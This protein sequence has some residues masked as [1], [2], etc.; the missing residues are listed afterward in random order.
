MEKK[1]QIYLLVFLNDFLVFLWFLFLLFKC[2]HNIVLRDNLP[3]YKMSTVISTVAHFQRFIRKEKP[4]TI[5][6]PSMDSFNEIYNENYILYNFKKRT[7]QFD[8]LT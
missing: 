7:R 6:L 8:S 1:K 2:V 5:F 3:T 4:T